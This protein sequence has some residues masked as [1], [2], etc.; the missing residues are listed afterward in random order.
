MNR[1]LRISLHRQRKLVAW[2]GVFA[3]FLLVFMPLLSQG[4]QWFAPPLEPEVCS[5]DHGVAHTPAQ[6]PGKAPAQPLEH[7]LDHCGY[8]NLLTHTPAVTSGG[9]AVVDFA[10]PAAVAQ[11]VADAP[12]RSSDRYP[13]ALAR[14]P[15]RG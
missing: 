3:V 5:A 9:T 8:C 11:P 13:R 12:L 15:P 6:A 2:L 14:A 10:P 7:L 1:P 4:M